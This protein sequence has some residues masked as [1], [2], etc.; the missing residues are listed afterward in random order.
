ML[1]THRSSTL[2][3]INTKLE[4]S[5]KDCLKQKS[6]LKIPLLTTLISTATTVTAVKGIPTICK[7][8]R[9][10]RPTVSEHDI[11]L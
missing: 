9:A 7:D 10:S 4:N 1:Y 3:D 11:T 6:I 8:S 5:W 2:R